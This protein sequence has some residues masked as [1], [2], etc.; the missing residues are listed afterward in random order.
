[1]LK[2]DEKTL[3]LSAAVMAAVLTLSGCGETKQAETLIEQS[4]IAP[5]E[6]NYETDVVEYG[7]YVRT[8]SESVSIYY[9]R[10]AELCWDQEG[11]YLEEILVKGGDQVKKGDVLATF[12]TDVDLIRIE[13]LQL[14][15]ERLRE[16][17]EIE[18]TQRLL[19]IQEKE[20]DYAEA[21]QK[22]DKRREQGYGDVNTAELDSYTTNIENLTIERMR[23]EYDEY[24]YQTEY[25]ISQMQKEIE[26][27]QE[28]AADNKLTAPF[29]GMI[30]IVFSMDPGEKV[31]T[32][33]VL[34]TMYATDSM[35][36]YVKDLSGF[37]RYNMDVSVEAGK[38]GERQTFT[39]KVVAA[40]NIL[41]AEFAQK[42][43]LI[44][45]DEEADPAVLQR[46][47]RYTVEVQS[48]DHVLTVN[49]KAVEEEND[50]TFVYVLNGDMLQKRY[51]V[52][53]ASNSEETWI[54]DGLSEGQSVVID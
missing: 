18:K 23:L 35:L 48:L 8:S 47:A 7:S 49:R 4:L 50:E 11:C 46:K 25:E 1:M 2:I 33:K 52:T 51:V 54:L 53:G 17:S 28:A 19:E 36:L 37:F 24:V 43:S 26:Q 21:K 12:D 30:E 39:G 42:L 40:S 32:Q 16:S 10:K 31:D 15:I 44:Q 9:P 34:I 3:S 5:T 6:V 38:E 20:E 22:R 14:K 27:L 29:D 13:E 41:P 45:L